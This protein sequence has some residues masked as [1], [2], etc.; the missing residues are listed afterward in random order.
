MPYLAEI[1]MFRAMLRTMLRSHNPFSFLNLSQASFSVLNTAPAIILCSVVALV[2]IWQS[3][4]LVID[5]DLLY[6]PDVGSS[7]AKENVPYQGGPLQFPSCI[8]S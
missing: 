8:V 6:N 4:R 3:V 2:E 5:H 1:V 7:M